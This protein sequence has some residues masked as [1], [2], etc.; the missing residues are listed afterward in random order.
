MANSGHVGNRRQDNTRYRT[1][2]RGTLIPHEWTVLR[3]M[4]PPVRVARSQDR[5]SIGRLLLT[6]WLFALVGACGGGT[7]GGAILPPST[8]ARGDLLRNPPELLATVPS[9]VALALLS[10]AVRLQIGSAPAPI[11]DISVY[12][13]RY[14]TVGGAGEPTTASAA[15]MVPIG[16]AAT[17]NGSRP[18]ML[19]AHGT[20]TDRNYNIGDL[21]A[22]NLEG[23]LLAVFFATQ[24]YIVIAPNY[25]GY[26]TSMLGYHPYLVAEQQSKDMID[27]LRASRTA[28][29]VASL[30]TVSDSG[31]LFITGYSQGG[32]VAMATHRAMQDAGMAVT[33]S[34]PMSGPYSMNAFVDAVVLGEVNASAPLSFALLATSYQRTYADIY[35]N[36][37]EVYE[38]EYAPE[39]GSLLPSTIP[40]AELYTRGLLPELALFSATPPDAASADTTP[41]TAPAEFAATYA[42]GFGSGNLVTNA[43]RLTYIQDARAHPDG[44]WPFATSELPSSSAAL[45][46]RRAL[47]RNDLRSWVPT[48]PVLLCGGHLDPTVFWLNTQL[49]SGYWGTHVPTIGLVQTLDVDSTA[50]A[51]DPYA[52]EKSAF[53]SAKDAVAIAAILQGATDGGASAVAATYHAGLVAP[54]CLTAV[55]HYFDSF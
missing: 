22:N 12:R 43:Y 7:G 34:A 37:A 53:S 54:A 47:A 36:P 39:I 48:R 27:A 8:P 18:M 21:N 32:Y 19:Y 49:M 10:D 45:P 44:G 9:G 30:A 46:L 55:R 28:L 51:G 41:A 4:T 31:K 3:S 15:L 20:T 24:G 38:P 11:C 42:R 25:A 40:R 50:A 16:T 35:S 26:D 17:C 23:L 33:A 52:S 14:Q 13:V 1:R 29:P 2:I 6:A 5:R